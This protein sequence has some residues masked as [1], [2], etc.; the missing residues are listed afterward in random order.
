MVEKIKIIFK[1]M[2]WNRKKRIMLKNRTKVKNVKVKKA[3]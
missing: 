2:L 3:I 1:R